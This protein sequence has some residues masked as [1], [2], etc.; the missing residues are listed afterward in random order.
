VSYIVAGYVVALSGLALY[1]LALV[2]RRYR[3]ERAAR[4]TV[5]SGDGAEPT[6]SP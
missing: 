1:A 2:T 4:V 5:A 3:L 6:A